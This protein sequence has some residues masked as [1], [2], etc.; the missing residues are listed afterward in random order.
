MVFDFWAAQRKA[1]S[2]TTLYLTVFIA[3]T[4]GMAILVEYVLRSWD[5]E[6]YSPDFPF[7][8][9]IFL[10][11]TFGVAF[12]QYLTYR[13][14]GGSYVAESVGARRV[15][16]AYATSQEQQLLNLV[17]EISVAAGVPMPAVYILEAEE[18]NAFAA[19]ITQDKAAVTVTTGI[20]QGL[21]RDELQGVIAHE[22]GHIYNGDMAISLRL[23]AMVMG[24]F[25]VLY[26]AIR[27]VQFGRIS[28]DRRGGPNILAL[29]AMI[30]AAAGAFTYFAGSVLKAT[31]SR[32]REYLA[33]ACAVQFTRNPEGIA[34]A[35]RKI[36]KE[37]VH[38]MPSEGMA[39][40]HMYFND[41]TFLSSFFATHPP[42][43]KRI[44]AIEGRT[45]MP[46]EWKNG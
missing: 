18:M 15:D 26:L 13:T 12:F 3:L 23:A 40:S 34:N 31:V 35:L 8:G 25:F 45:Y 5:P 17:E 22:F 30:L 36:A 38:D 39:I 32:Q 20:M 41:A 37:P 24:F 28:S 46:E 6:D 19:G 21:N 44:A 4:I 9:F 14:Q 29:G 2:R 1:K 16:P 27:L 11:I 42:I 10:A 33:D 7:I 43:G